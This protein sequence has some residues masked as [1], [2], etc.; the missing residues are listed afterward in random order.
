MLNV[1]K[2]SSVQNSSLRTVT[3]DALAKMI[4]DNPALSISLLCEVSFV[5]ELLEKLLAYPGAL[6]HILR[7]DSSPRWIKKMAE[8]SLEEAGYVILS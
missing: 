1:I 5:E 4:M 2:K 3:G 6:E 7:S 8:E